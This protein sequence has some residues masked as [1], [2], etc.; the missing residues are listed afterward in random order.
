[1]INISILCYKSGFLKKKML[2]FFCMETNMP[3]MKTVMDLS[4]TNEL[5]VSDT[6][7]IRVID[8]SRLESERIISQ[9]FLNKKNQKKYIGQSVCNF[10]EST[11]KNKEKLWLYYIS[12]KPINME[13]NN[14]QDS[15]LDQ[16]TSPELVVLFKFDLPNGLENKSHSGNKSHYYFTYCKK[17]NPEDGEY[18][19]YNENYQYLYT[20]T[21]KFNPIISHINEKFNEDYFNNIKYFIKFIKYPG[22]GDITNDKIE[23]AFYI[24]LSKKYNEG[25]TN[26]NNEETKEHLERMYAHLKGQQLSKDLLNIISQA[27]K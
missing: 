10:N 13:D 26:A 1:M 17:I 3:I 6:E 2:D 19:I 23:D 16:I 7:K 22:T 9:Y 4:C 8:S 24:E 27:L 25:M 21:I 14:T 20:E 12:Q 18:S 11:D 15:D 5:V